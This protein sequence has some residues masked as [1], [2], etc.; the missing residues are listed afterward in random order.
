MNLLLVHPVCGFPHFFKGLITLLIGREEVGGYGRR[1]EEGPPTS[2]AP[3]PRKGAPR[4][5][6]VAPQKR[7]VLPGVEMMPV[8]QMTREGPVKRGA[9]RGESHSPL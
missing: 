6:W 5:G 3:S 1:A 8:R 2:P 7:H 9:R 4:E